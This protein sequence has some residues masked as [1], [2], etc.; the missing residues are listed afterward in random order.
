MSQRKSMVSISMELLQESLRLRKSMVISED[1]EVSQDV[2]NISEEPQKALDGALFAY[3]GI[4]YACLAFFYLIFRTSTL[5]TGYSWSRNSLAEVFGVADGPLMETNNKSAKKAL[6]I[7]CYIGMVLI[8]MIAYQYLSANFFSSKNEA[9]IRFFHRLVGRFLVAMWPVVI[10]VAY[11]FFVL[12]NTDEDGGSK[13]MVI[14]STLVSSLT[15]FLSLGNIV[16]G[17]FSIAHRPKHLRNY[18]RHKAC[19]FFG[20][21]YAIGFTT[22][23][24]AVMVIQIGFWNSCDIS[25]QGEAIGLFVGFALQTLALVICMYIY[26]KNYF[27]EKEVYVN[28]ILLVFHNLVFL[29]VLVG[30]FVLVEPED[31]TCFA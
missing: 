28:L 15:G 7:H 9:T 18:F 4:P 24:V 2:E 25:T 10:I 14:A 12:M 17:Y 27:K 30:S 3:I 19:M 11:I 20:M 5:I 29:F 26:D 23:V 22:A 13:N 1:N 21:H 8:G 16:V 6:D 31:G